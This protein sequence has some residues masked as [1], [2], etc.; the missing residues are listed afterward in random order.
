MQV[1]TQSAG[2]VTAPASAVEAGKAPGAIAPRLVAVRDGSTSVAALIDAYM[3]AY[4]GRD[5]TRAQRLAY[6]REHVGHL[7]LSEID[8]DIIFSCMEALAERRGTFYAGKDARGAPIF[9]AKRRALT[10]ATLNRYQAALSAVLTWAQRR[11]MTPRGWANPC[12]A[13]EMRRERNAR[14]RF[15]DDAERERL[16]RA[17]RN[18]RQAKLYMFVLLALTT[19]ARRGELEGLRWCDVDFERGEAHVARTKNGDA[20]LLVLVP[21]AV[22]ELRRHAGAPS[23]LVFAS[24]RARARA[25]AVDMSHAWRVALKDAQIKDFRFHDCRHDAASTLAKAGA[26]LLEIG[27]VLGHRQQQVTK[28]YAHL[29]GDHKK[30]LVRRVMAGVGATP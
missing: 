29:C 1:A 14:V 13:L 7:P 24:S 10:P 4:D 2:D 6:W 5:T 21:A 15:L 20:R 16:L 19:G 3:V 12:R 9:K 18:S 25:A 26:S 28:R 30:A 11:R 27:D 8:D 23:T 17:C 22:E